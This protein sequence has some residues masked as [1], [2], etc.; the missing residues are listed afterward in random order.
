MWE[1]IHR[2]FYMEAFDLKEIMKKAGKILGSLLF[3]ALFA[4]SF[5]KIN[6]IVIS[7]TTNRYYIMDHDKNR[8][9]QTYDVLV[10]GSC[11]AYNSFNPIQLIIL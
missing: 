11:H 3:L 5:I 6:D 7:K 4:L 9:A 10:F 2:H 8:N 1:S